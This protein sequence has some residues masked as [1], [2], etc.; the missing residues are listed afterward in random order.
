M[1]RRALLLVVAV[2]LGLWM[3]G[4]ARARPSS[5]LS[6]STAECLEEGVSRYASDWVLLRHGELQ[7]LKFRSDCQQ[8]Y[9]LFTLTQPSGDTRVVFA[10]QAD[11]VWWPIILDA[12]GL[13]RVPVSG[14]GLNVNSAASDPCFY[15]DVDLVLEAD[16]SIVTDPC[17]QTRIG[18]R[19]TSGQAGVMSSSSN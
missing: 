2:V 12:I 19:L 16:G 14:T 6:N 10:P 11:A 9:A 17:S 1:R 5:L 8:N 7:R 3:P 18:R 13:L 15:S 4:T